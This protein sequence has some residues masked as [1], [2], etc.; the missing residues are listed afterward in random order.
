MKKIGD[1]CPLFFSPMGKYPFGTG[2]YTQK[3]HTSDHILLQVVSDGGESVTGTLNNLVTGGSSAI[4]F[5]TYQQNDTVKV[6]HK[7]FSDLPD[8][9]YSVTV[10]GIGES[11]P[12]C[13][14]SS[15]YMDGLT[16]RIRYSHKDNNSF[17]NVF[18]LGDTQQFFDLRLECGFKPGGYLPQVS[19]EQYRNQRQEIVELYAMPYDQWQLTLGDVCGVPVWFLRLVNRILCLSHVEIGG[20][21]WARSEQS[22]PEKV[23]VTEDST[24]FQATVTLEP[25]ENEVSGVGGVPEEAVQSNT[26]AFRI[27][28]P[29]DGQLLQYSGEASAFENVT[30]VRM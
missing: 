15:D 10:G 11:E 27:D 21:L 20:R 3:F 9:V 2:C 25:L 5:S 24:L 19:N 17:D 13:V 1:V 7:D 30:T 6:W 8:G 12:F 16:T 14:E 23:Q 29:K 28:T 26:V 22:V 18:W 4:S